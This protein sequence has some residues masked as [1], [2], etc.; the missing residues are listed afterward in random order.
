[1]LSRSHQEQW[2]CHT[3]TVGHNMSHHMCP[4]CCMPFGASFTMHC[5]G[6]VPFQDVALSVLM[7]LSHPWTSDYHIRSATLTCLGY[8]RALWGLSPIMW[9]PRLQDPV[10]H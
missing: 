8:T 1:M 9:P 2:C 5:E 6:S 10:W 7:F 3:P 4:S